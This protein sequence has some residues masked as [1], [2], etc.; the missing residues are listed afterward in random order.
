M[1]K[2]VLGKLLSFVLPPFDAPCLKTNVYVSLTRITK[3]AVAERSSPNKNVKHDMLESFLA[4]VLTQREIQ[5]A[6]ILQ[7]YYTFPNPS[8]PNSFSRHTTSLLIPTPIY[9]VAGS[10]NSATA[11]GD[12]ALHHTTASPAVLQ[13]LLSEM[14]SAVPSNLT[15]DAQPRERINTLV[16]STTT[17]FI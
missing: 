5:M 10:D 8:P 14:T 9:S 16:C 13:K 11:L 4:H 6:T 17:C 7:M 2:I 12:V 1:D 3:T 15:N